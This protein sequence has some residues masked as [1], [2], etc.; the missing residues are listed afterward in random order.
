M[1]FL[2]EI[3]NYCYLA[4]S[5]TENVVILETDYLNVTKLGGNLYYKYKHTMHIL[6]SQVRNSEEYTSNPCMTVSITHGW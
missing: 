6:I 2:Y 1:T 5:E 4:I 3:L